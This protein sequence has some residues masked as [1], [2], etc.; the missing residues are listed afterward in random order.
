MGPRS[1]ETLFEETWPEA[2]PGGAWPP[3]RSQEGKLVFSEK[4]RKGS[5]GK[6]MG[7]RKGLCCAHSCSFTDEVPFFPDPAPPF[8][9]SHRLFIVAQPLAQCSAILFFPPL[10]SQMAGQPWGVA[11]C[12]ERALLSVCWRITPCRPC[13]WPGLVL[14]AQRK[15][16]HSVGKRAGRLG[17]GSVF[18]VLFAEVL[19]PLPLLEPPHPLRGRG[20]SVSILLYRQETVAQR[21]QGTGAQGR[22][23][24]KQGARVQASSPG[25]CL[26]RARPSR[27]PQPGFSGL[28]WALGRG[29]GCKQPKKDPK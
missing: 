23:A 5:Q 4:E 9:G 25:P 6:Q 10:H 19:S 12:G 1:A 24:G 13:T 14:L 27:T 16:K 22:T 18:Y 11:P 3:G 21:A 29:T 8:L 7:R 26:L 2:L 17:W 28:C 15:W 20:V